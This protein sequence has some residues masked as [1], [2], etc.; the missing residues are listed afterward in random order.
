MSRLSIDKTEQI[1]ANSIEIYEQEIGDLKLKGNNYV[2]L[3]PLHGEHTPSFNINSNYPH[4]FKCFGCG[5]SGNVISFE[6]GRAHV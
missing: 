1:I 6:I 2:G 4:L 3:C 5:E